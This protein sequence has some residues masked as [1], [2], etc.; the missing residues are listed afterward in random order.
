MLAG[1]KAAGIINDPSPA[2]RVY[3]P[4]HPDADPQ[5]YAAQRAAFERAGCLVTETAARASLAAAAIASRRPE[6]AGRAL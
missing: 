6:L 1:V 3:D 2:R 4:G 5:G